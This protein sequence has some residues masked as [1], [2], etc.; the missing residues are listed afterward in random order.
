MAKYARILNP[1]VVLAGWAAFIA[2]QFIAEPIQRLVLLA[3]AR[4]LP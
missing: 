4:L 2:G 3:A 1:A